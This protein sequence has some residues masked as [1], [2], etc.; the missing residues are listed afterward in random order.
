MM[1]FL[2]AVAALSASASAALAQTPLAIGVKHVGV[3][4]AEDP[5]NPKG[6]FSDC[7]S[8]D[9]LPGDQLTVSVTT[10]GLLRVGR[11]SDCGAVGTWDLQDTGIGWFSVRVP[12]LNFQAS[13][14]TYLISV[15]HPGLGSYS[16]SVDRAAGGAGPVLPAGAP[17][18]QAPPGTASTVN[19]GETREAGS[20]FKDCAD[21][22]HMT[23]LPAGSFLMGSPP[24]LSALVPPNEGPRHS[25]TFAR[26]FAMGTYEVTFAEYD[27][28][29]A[30]GSC[31]VSPTDEGWGRDRRPV[32]NV[33]FAQAVQYANW[34]S[35]KT[36][37]PYFIPSEAEWEYAAR[38]G[39]DTLWNT[40]DAIITDDANIL[41]HFQKTVPVGGYPPNAFGLY[42]THG[43]VW[44]WTLD[45]LDSGYVG[46]PTNGAAASGGDCNAQAIVRGGSYYDEPS[47]V[48]SAVRAPVSRVG[49]GGKVGFRVAR[50]L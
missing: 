33:N 28:C 43:N 3:L 19:G 25:V 36:G 13:G 32:I 23:V 41:N 27:L 48:R 44:E 26:P 6:E 35:A 8:V 39:S 5:R 1:R 42:D 31:G 29:V 2:F 47:H 34:L 9:T 37:K 40:G 20:T 4:T 16:I 50:A 12:T 22:P 17:V 10:N 15:G 45:C 24:E 7:Y 30:A 14:G 18:L 11:G 46:A 21:C 49:R 38:A